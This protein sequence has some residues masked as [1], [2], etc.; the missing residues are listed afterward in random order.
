[1]RKENKYREDRTLSRLFRHRPAHHPTAKIVRS[2]LSCSSRTTSI[3]VFN[4]CPLEGKVN[5]KPSAPLLFYPLMGC[6]IGWF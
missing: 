5:A 4:Y 2:F 6:L 1:M 3:R